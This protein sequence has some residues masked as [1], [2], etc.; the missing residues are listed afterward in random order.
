MGVGDNLSFSR[1]F[2]VTVNS[3][4]DIP[5]LAPIDDLTIEEDSTEQTVNLTDIYA[6]RW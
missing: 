2:E 6:R 4:N 3:V 1:T 5:L